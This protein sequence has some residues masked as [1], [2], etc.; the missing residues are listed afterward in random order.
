MPE[1]YVEHTQKQPKSMGIYK[2]HMTSF[3]FLNV[4][5]I[6]LKETI[7]NLW[8]VINNEWHLVKAKLITLYE[9]QQNSFNKYEHHN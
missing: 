3:N 9:Y 4:Y 8:E 1:A 6:L 2:I 7:Q 5:E